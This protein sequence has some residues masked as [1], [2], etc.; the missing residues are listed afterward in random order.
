MP[1]E[2]NVLETE[3][4]PCGK[5]PMTGYLRDGCCHHISDDRGRHEVCAV[6]TEEFL[7]FSKRN[8]ND[9]MT[10]RPE[11]A[12]SGL[13]PG[14]RWCVCLGRWIEA[15]DADVAPPV[16]L[17]ATNEAV[18]EEVPFSTLNTHEYV[19]LEYDF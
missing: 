2:L 13:K 1:D 10:P 3:L 14:D 5:D 11:L 6:M 19:E 18:L 17:E 4:R 8:G 16:V 12:F 15:L 9:L 7:Q